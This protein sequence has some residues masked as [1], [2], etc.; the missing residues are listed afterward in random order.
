MPKGRRERVGQLKI[1]DGTK[2]RSETHNDGVE[3]FE[4]V[5]ITEFDI[6]VPSFLGGLLSGDQLRSELVLNTRRTGEFEEEPRES[7]RGRFVAGEEDGLR[8]GRS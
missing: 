4:L 1:N 3:I 2:D 6:L 5:E 7:V 8:E